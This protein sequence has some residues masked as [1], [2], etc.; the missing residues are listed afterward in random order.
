MDNTK[1]K[2]VVYK[3]KGMGSGVAFL[4]A[5]VMAIVGILLIWTFSFSFG[6]GTI[7]IATLLLG[8]LVIVFVASSRKKVVVREEK[9]REVEKVVEKPVVYKD[10][11]V[12]KTQRVM[13]KP[14]LYKFVGSSESKVYHRTHSRLARLIRPKNRVYSNSESFFKKK[15][16]KSSEDIKDHKK[17]ERE[18]KAKTSSKKRVSKKK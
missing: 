3:T 10:R 12:L 9:V 1:G 16:F 5:V 8:Y 18:E 11:P 4:L 17:E 13:P 6:E 7:V 15:G 14:K 2:R